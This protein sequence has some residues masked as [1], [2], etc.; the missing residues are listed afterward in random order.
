MSS[1]EPVF[2]AAYLIGAQSGVLHPSAVDAHY[3]SN[4]YTAMS[5]V[6]EGIRAEFAAKADALK[7]SIKAAK[8]GRLIHA[9][10]FTGRFGYVKD[11]LERTAK[12]AKERK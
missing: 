5:A 6:V 1:I 7:E 9:D 4:P 11:I 12:Q 10:E 2:D 3:G 8:D